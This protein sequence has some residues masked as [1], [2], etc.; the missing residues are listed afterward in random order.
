MGVNE[1]TLRRHYKK[2]W[3]GF[4]QWQQLIHAE[5][6]LLYPQNITAHMAIDEVSLSQ[7]ELYTILSSRDRPGRKGKIAAVIRGTKAEDLITVLSKLP[8]SLRESV[9]EVTLDMSMSMVK[10][11]QWAFPMAALVTDRFHVERLSADAVQQARIDQRWKE[12]DREAKAIIK[13]RKQGTKYKPI[14]LTNGDTPKQLLARS[15]YILYKMP[16]QW[17]KSQIHRAFLLFQLY[18]SI[19]QAYSLHLNFK[20]IYKLEDLQ[21]AKT[22]LV[23]WI[24]RAQDSS[25]QYFQSV[26]E[27]LIAHW[28]RIVAFFTN[29]S[30]NVHAESLN[31]QIKLFRSNLRG[32]TDT[33][34]FLYRLEKIFA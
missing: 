23:D 5:K 13:S 4:H 31:A 27:S 2:N 30:T 16:H 20:N 15:R 22:A 10:A 34:F 29:R 32:V 28:E 1:D 8:E 6:Y 7:G 12:I 24:K 17:T 3:S 19:E 33:K 9:K 11:A 21:K 26:A 25:I 18:P 14:I